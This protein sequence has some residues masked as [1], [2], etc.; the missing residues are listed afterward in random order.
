[1]N[2]NNVSFPYPVLGSYDDI[3]PTPEEPEVEVFQDK[4]F[5]H[6]VI[7]LKYNNPDIRKLVENNYADY[8]CEVKCEMTR[9][10]KCYVGK[11]LHF[12]IDIPRKNVAGRIVFSCT[13]TVKR[14]IKDY[15]NQGF[16]PDYYGHSFTME[17]GDILGIFPQFYYVADIKYDKLKA[18]GTFMEIAETKDD[19][20]KTILENDKIEL[21]LPSE[22]YQLYK[23]S[24]TVN[25]QSDILHSSLVMN[26][27]IYA[28]CRIDRYINTKWA[29]TIM[30]RV[31]TEEELKNFRE[32][33]SDEWQVDIL[34]HKLLGK[35]YNRLFNYLQSIQTNFD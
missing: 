8:V 16:H 7:E 11:I 15:I 34:A 33:N 12:Q 32:Q 19:I 20:P 28:L 25:S 4:D 18:V 14:T 5:Y 2:L 31:D 9:Y 30:F 22:L 13:I 6:F 10:V 24:P 1:M 17:P 21:L 29:Q 27:L 23:N 3:L 26:A 35:P